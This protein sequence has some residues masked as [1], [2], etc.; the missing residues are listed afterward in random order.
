MNPEFEMKKKLEAEKNANGQRFVSAVMELSR[1][2][3]LTYILQQNASQTK[4]ES[5]L[6]LEYKDVIKDYYIDEDQV[7]HTETDRS[8][9]KKLNRIQE[10]ESEQELI[11]KECLLLVLSHFSRTLEPYGRDFYD[12]LKSY[13][14]I[15][16]RDKHEE[17]ALKHKFLAEHFGESHAKTARQI[18]DS[19]GNEIIAQEKKLIAGEKYEKSALH[20]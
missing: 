11:E 14:A 1:G 17:E 16:K 10:F 13:S 2:D 4:K 5:E 15:T 18:I 19:I 8:S 20:M 7:S 9:P 6:R 12:I 3:S